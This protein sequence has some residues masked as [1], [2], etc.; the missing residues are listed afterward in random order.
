MSDPSAQTVRHRRVS[1]ELKKMREQAGRTS[2][3]AADAMGWHRTKV[4]RLER[5]EWK[6]LRE[7]D[8]R[9]LA[10]YYGVA[11][12]RHV[13]AL[14]ALVKV[15]S[16]RGWW[17]HYKD[18]LGPGSYVSLEAQATQLR[19]YSGMLV[20]GLLQTPAYSEAIMRVGRI[21]DEAEIQ[22]RLEAR[23]ARKALLERGDRPK[24]QVIIDQAALNKCI[25]SPE[26]MAEQ[27]LHLTRLQQDGAIE[28]GIIPD[29]HGAHAALT[30]QFVILDFPG[31][32]DDSAVFI[33]NAHNGIFLEEMDEVR[34]YN[35]VF[36]LTWSGCLT[37]TEAHAFLVNTAKKNVE[38]ALEVEQ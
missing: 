2:Y 30:G 19:F 13:D 26:M 37:G 34:D 21:Q 11:D 27:A 25:G 33:D 12:R 35:D 38:R 8:V 7:A 23:S 9:S 15:A 20:P 16:A 1:A 17:S 14:V 18:V 22:R 36:E 3:E 5:G 32:H 10:E 31:T 29:S 6:R 24:V 4:H 28:I